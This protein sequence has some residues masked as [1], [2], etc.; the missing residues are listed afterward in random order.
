MEYARGSGSRSGGGNRTWLTSVATCSHVCPAAVVR[1]RCM[2][3]LW[4]AEK[5]RQDTGQDLSVK[6]CSCLCAGVCVWCRCACVVFSPTHLP[7]NIQ[8]ADR[9]LSHCL[10]FPMLF[11]LPVCMSFSS[12]LSLSRLRPLSLS[13]HPTN[14]E[15]SICG[16]QSA[17][18]TVSLSHS[19]YLCLLPT[20]LPEKLPVVD[21]PTVV[22]EV[23]LARGLPTARAQQ[24]PQRLGNDGLRCSDVCIHI[25]YINGRRCSDTC[26]IGVEGCG[27]CVPLPFV[28][29][30][31][32]LRTQAS[33]M[34]PATG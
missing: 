8:V 16:L 26:K 10:Y 33:S 14:E 21:W 19:V 20:H 30:S 31:H 27:A 3:L 18:V 24:G 17:C 12:F 11:C 15:K 6:A 34:L 1:R 4:R 32:M 29:A 28:H 5:L 9:C 13:T 22:D 25:V 7:K 23:R 2:W